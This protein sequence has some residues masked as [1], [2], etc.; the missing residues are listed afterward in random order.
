MQSNSTESSRIAVELPQIQKL[1]SF[2][3]EAITASARQLVCHFAAGDLQRPM[4]HVEADWEDVFQTICRNGVVGLTYTYLK[5]HPDDYP[6]ATFR[7]WIAWAHLL[8]TGH[9][10]RT[11]THVRTVLSR[12]AEAGL[13]FLVLKGPALAEQVYQDP[14]LRWYGDL[15]IHVRDQDL[16]A[17]HQL[18]LSLGLRLQEAVTESPPKLVA[19]APGAEWHYASEDGWFLVELH[20]DDLLHTGLVPRDYDGLWERAAHI[21]VQGI[22]VQVLSLE[23]QLIAL[24]AHVHYHGY[25]RLNWL[26]DIAFIV[27]DHAEELDWDRLVQTI[28]VEEVQV[29]VYYTLYFL[30]RM[31]G[32]S[33]PESTLARIRPDWFRRWLHERYVPEQ[34]VVSLLPMPRPD[35]SFYFLP[36]FKRLLPDLLV[37]GRRPEKLHYLLRLLV[38][39][40]A[41]LRHYY[42]VEDG[43]GVARHYVLHPLKLGGHYLASVA[44]SIAWLCH[45]K[46]ADE[47]G[48]LL[49]WWSVHP[50][51]A[52]T[53]S[54]H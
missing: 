7:K 18:L 40:P 23:D 30:D 45:P 4:P 52:R 22:P 14:A 25:T 33:I 5:H 16:A 37:M 46:H 48:G 51:V 44:T 50:H 35:F 2:E 42:G 21:N 6:P 15:D 47:T 38:P 3:R 8:A 34:K 11:R 24:S 29:P 31:L 13:D 32:V 43:E 12:L 28:Q 9:M 39:S 27:R 41:W 54:C 19:Q 36:L 49:S 17:A 10:A 20:G 53:R 26:S 1:G